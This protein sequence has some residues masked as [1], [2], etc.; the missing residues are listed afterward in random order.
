MQSKIITLSANTSWY[1]YNFRSSTINEFLKMGFRVVCI[2]PRDDFSSRLESLGCEWMSI[3]IDNKGTNFLN[4]FLLFFR[5]FY[6]YKKLKPIAAFHFTIKNNIYGT[7]AASLLKIYS[8]NNITGLGTAFIKKNSISFIVKI[9]YKLSQPFAF[10]V[11]CQN[12]EDYSFLINENLVS[13]NKLFLL[14]GSGVNLERFSP[15]YKKSQKAHKDVFRLLFCGRMLADKGLFELIEALKEINKSKIKCYLLL[16]GFI[17]KKNSSAISREQVLSW[18]ALEWLEWRGSTNKI[19]SVMSSVDGLVLP[20]Y[21]EGM[22]KTLLEACAMELPIIASDV[23]GC[24]EVI[25]DGENGFLCK[26]KDSQSL[27][28]AILKLISMTRN[29]R[30]IMGKKGRSIVQDKFDEKY[31]IE[32]AVSTLLEVSDILSDSV[33]S[34]R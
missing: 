5:F 9:L 34:G 12:K 18:N 16:Y 1:L 32:S 7:W 26:S 8:I 14:P 13:S 4:D 20:S 19:E 28:A 31:V 21:R 25:K 2:S 24:N 11:F 30:L 17:D 29:D 23:P 15:K 22:P 10:K 3:K 6:L 27:K 33:Q